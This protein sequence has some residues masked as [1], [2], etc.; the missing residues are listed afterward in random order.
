MWVCGLLLA[1]S[2]SLAVGADP[3]PRTEL[4]D[5]P[6]GRRVSVFVDVFQKGD[7]PGI[8]GFFE[9]NLSAQALSQRPAAE[10]A[11][12]ILRLRTDL[13]QVTVRRADERP[14]AS[15]VVIVEGERQRL[16]KLTF[17]FAPALPHH[18]LGIKVDD[19]DADDLAG[20]PRPMTESEALTAIEQAMSEAA[21]ADTFSGVV[22][23]ARDG[24][25]L[26]HKAWGL[27]SR[28]FAVA[29]RPDTKFNLG[30]IN[31]L[32]TQ[33]ALGQLLEQGRISLD[34]PLGKHLPDYPNREAASRVTIRHL[35]AMQSGI[36]NIFGPKFEA[37]PKDRLRR[38][39]DFLP[40]F[41]AEPL[42]FEPGKESRYS[43]GG[44]VVLGEVIARVSGED[45]HDYVRKHVFQ[46]AGMA[47]TDS[48]EADAVVPNLAEG[49]TRDEEG[50]RASNAPRR[51][52]VYSRPARGSAAGGGYSTAEDLLRFA[53][54][55]L[56][57]RLLTPAWTDWIV[58]RVEPAP[59][60][61]PADR[62]RGGIAYTG[63]APG[64]NA[65]LELD[66]DPAWTVIVLA[67]DDPPTANRM[68]KKV[69]RLIDAI[70]N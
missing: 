44:Y 34:D 31:K 20:P 40:L 26:L 18:L 51:R 13:G 55:L 8:V 10:R 9:R 52:N 65:A 30:S 25:P 14:P 41:A 53:S 38:N 17:D 1:G 64:I 66:R 56:A 11:D 6:L 19:A 60:R 23:V 47:D 46:P 22:L 59:G 21:A 35:V 43:N 62:T 7:R 36:G 33:V 58:A 39:A 57:D 2:L 29:N 49:Y 50:E 63:G 45:Y 61:P 4:P 5:T 68:A 70:Q 28:E 15:V 42:L 48:Y 24:R 3:S 16:S 27:A 69:R 12:R 37:T 32:F 67:N 54:A